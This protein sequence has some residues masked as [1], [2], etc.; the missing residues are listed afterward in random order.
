MENTSNSLE[1]IGVE[2]YSFNMH[3]HAV[4]FDCMLHISA[5]SSSFLMGASSAS[6]VLA[7]QKQPRILRI[8]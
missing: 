8:F 6:T 7:A 1:I 4:S 2:L 5:T 3:V